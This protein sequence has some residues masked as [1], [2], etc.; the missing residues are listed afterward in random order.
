LS[1]IDEGQCAAAPSLLL[2][3]AR[4]LE[5]QP[6]AT[7]FLWD[8]DSLIAMT[9][10]SK[11]STEGLIIIALATVPIVLLALNELRRRWPIKMIFD[12]QPYRAEGE[13]RLRSSATVGLGTSKLHVV[14]MPRAP[15]NVKSLDIRF[16]GHDIFQWHNAWSPQ[17]RVRN[18]EIPQWNQGPRPSAIAQA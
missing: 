8:W 9:F 16:V 10:E 17:I 6:A 1:S 5:L 12:E 7:T 3:Q 15:I 14:L 4:L 18:V 11:F 13:H 2:Y